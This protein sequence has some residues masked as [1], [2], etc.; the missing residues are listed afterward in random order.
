[1]S[2]GYVWIHSDTCATWGR[3]YDPGT[4]GN[5]IVTF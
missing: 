2:D 1:M 3:N 5:F 4:Y